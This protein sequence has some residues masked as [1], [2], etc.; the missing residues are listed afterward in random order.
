MIKELRT[1]WINEAGGVVPLLSDKSP[2]PRASDGN[3]R[4]TFT[5]YVK[6]VSACSVREALKTFAEQVEV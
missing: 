2:D 3:W 4:K 1:F 6:Q 5:L